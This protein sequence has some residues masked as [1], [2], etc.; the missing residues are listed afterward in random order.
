MKSLQWLLPGF[1]LMVL[2]V[3][4]VGQTLPALPA[5][6]GV[7]ISASM[8]ASPSGAAHGVESVKGS[9]FSADVVYEFTHVLGDENRIHRESHG[10]IFRDGEGRIRNEFEDELPRTRELQ[11]TIQDP[12]SQTFV[13]LYPQSVNKR[14]VV[15][16][17]T[18]VRDAAGRPLGFGFADSRRAA[19]P[20]SAAGAVSP[21]ELLER[22]KALQLER[23]K[24]LQQVQKP[25]PA[26]IG[27]Q[28]VRLPV[29]GA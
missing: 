21:E 29:P 25:A 27:N 11:I 13:T 20:T 17:T 22:L 9:P 4:A 7:S 19:E 18:V 12:V 24:A 26:T 16:H 1:F 2:P 6:P 15:N 14:A 8:I 10:K 5:P 3:T 23:L 28:E